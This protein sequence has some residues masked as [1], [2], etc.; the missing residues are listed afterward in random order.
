MNAPLVLAS[1]DLV[2]P[3]CMTGKVLGVLDCVVAG[4]E[5][6]WSPSRT[7]CAAFQSIIA[8]AKNGSAETDASPDN[9][10]SSAEAA[11]ILGVSTRRVRQLGADIGG[12]QP[13]GRGH[14]VFDA[15]AIYAEAARR[16]RA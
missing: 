6:H 15:G 8:A 10:I 3:K 7:A 11:R 2:I 5:E 4:H 1:G 12:F 13:K 14:W 16:G 9:A